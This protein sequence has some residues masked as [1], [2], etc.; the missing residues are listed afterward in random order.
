VPPDREIHADLPDPDTWQRMGVLYE[1]LAQAVPTSAPPVLVVSGDCTTTLGVLAGLQRAGRDPG[2]V[3][4]DAH[5]DFNTEATSPSGYLGGLPVALAVGIGTLTLPHELRLRPVPPS[6]VVIVDARD[7]DPDESRLLEQSRV[8]RQELE[9]TEADLPDGDPHLHADVEICDPTAVPDLLFPAAD[10]PHLDDVVVGIRGVVDSRRVAAVE[11]A[12]TWHLNGPS[13][14]NQRDAMRRIAN[15]V[16]VD[17]TGQ[18]DAGD[19]N[20]HREALASAAS[21][22]GNMLNSIHDET[23][24]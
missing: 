15:A 19:T 21:R 14:S 6:R 16:D 12:T 10:G 22:R 23:S 7:V 24:E 2:I 3:W 20:G 9:L 11:L 17:M 5:G 13:A 4:I 18:T 1:H 8:E